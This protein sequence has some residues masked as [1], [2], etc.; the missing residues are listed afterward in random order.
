[1]RR[2]QRPCGVGDAGRLRPALRRVD[3]LRRPVCP[4]PAADALEAQVLR[5]IKRWKEAAEVLTAANQ[6]FS[7]DTDLIYE[8]AMVE[9]KLDRL[10]EITRRRHLL[11]TNATRRDRN[12]RCADIDRKS[13]V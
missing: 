10:P 4:L 8:Q 6:R 5:D 1:M 3:P 13:V 2:P 7:D 9:E 12:L 11:M